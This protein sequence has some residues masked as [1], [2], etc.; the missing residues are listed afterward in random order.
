MTP[1]EL[2][3]AQKLAMANPER[4]RLLAR[5]LTHPAGRA[6]A[7]DLV[8]FPAPDEL[9]R[10]AEALDVAEAEQELDAL[11]AVGL[12]AVVGP[13]PANGPVPDGPVDGPGRPP[14]PLYRVSARGISRFGAAAL[15]AP[16]HPGDAALDVHDHEVLLARLT[17]SLSAEFAANAGAETVDRLVRECYS[18]LSEQI[19]HFQHLPALTAW[20]ATDRL[21]A[22]TEVTH[23]SPRDVLFVCVH[24]TGRSQIAAAVTRRLAGDRIRV[25]TAGTRPVTEPSAM[26]ETVLARRG[27]DGLIEFPRELTDDIVRASGV[28]VTMGCGDSC[29]VYPGRRYLDWPLDDPA[30]RPIEEV[31]RIV[32]DITARV[33]TLLAEIDAAAESV[34]GDAADADPAG[35]RRASAPRGQSPQAARSE[36]PT[37]ASALDAKGQRKAR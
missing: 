6:T 32:D 5:M 1:D 31:E 29:P 2:R 10:G 21:A 15:A 28:I 36:W 8:R 30:G 34:Q 35:D 7:A 25:R 37:V 9:P 18:S 19:G 20:L 24:N 26:T 11:A 12:V 14:A 23:G 22:M 33:R 4:L 17:E 13:A 16:R 3:S 27:L